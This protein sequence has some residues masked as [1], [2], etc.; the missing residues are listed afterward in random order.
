MPFAPK[1]A[2]ERCEADCDAKYDDDQKYCEAHWKMHGRS[3]DAY[4]MCINNARK[5][6]LQ[7]YQ[8][9]KKECEK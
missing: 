6:Y 7:C 2:L 3:P 8:D 4:R 1:S 9:C 5:K